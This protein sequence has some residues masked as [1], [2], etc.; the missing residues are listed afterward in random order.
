MTLY[1]GEGNRENQGNMCQLVTQC[2]VTKSRGDQLLLSVFILNPQKLRNWVVDYG[3]KGQNRELKVI[4][5]C[6]S[7]MIFFS[8][9][10]KF[11]VTITFLTFR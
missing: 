7:S 5:N 9:R 10:G 11:N 2:Q 8:T 6:P 3:P 1:V 4:M